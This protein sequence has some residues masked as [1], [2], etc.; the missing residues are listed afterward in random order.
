M[1]EYDVLYAVE[2]GRTDPRPRTQQAGAAEPARAVPAP[3]QARRARHDPPRTR[4]GGRA[5]R[6]G[7]AH[8]RRPGDAA[9]RRRQTRRRRRQA[10][11]IPAVRQGSCGSWRP[12]AANSPTRSAPPRKT[13]RR[14]TES[15]RA[16]R[17]RTDRF[18][19]IVRPIGILADRQPEQ[20]VG[21]EPSGPV[22]PATVRAGAG[23]VHPHLGVLTRGRGRRHPMAGTR[24]AGSHRRRRATPRPGLQM[25]PSPFGQGQSPYGH[26]QP[27]PSQPGPS[28]YGPPHPGA[29]QPGPSPYDQT[30]IGPA[31]SPPGGSPADPS[32][33][34]TQIGPTSSQYG[35]PP[36][37]AATHRATPIRTT[38][39]RPIS[40]TANPRRG[41][42]PAARPPMVG[43][44]TVNRP[45]ASLR[46]VSR[47][48]GQRDTVSRPHPRSPS[49]TRPGTPR[50]RTEGSAAPP[51]RLSRPRARPT[52][53]RQWAPLGSARRRAPAHPAAP[54]CRVQ[55][56]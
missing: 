11:R 3:R 13:A 49:P 2:A 24:V 12:S 34:H 47:L 17:G 1:R 10:H 7:L 35:R 31:G 36:A 55:C 53:A 54:G 52:P 23:T 56:P 51:I 4:S 39:I 18:S 15:M 22:P 9:P 48:R 29:A 8:R 28:P 42:R 19:S 16:Q 40:R 6:A 46:T 43:P 30:Q 20:D 37:G 41:S 26:P 38:R 27:G 5:R 14:T 33:G 21:H 25:S 45:R 50:R 32:Y 44:R